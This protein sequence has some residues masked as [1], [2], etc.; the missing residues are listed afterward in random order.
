MRLTLF[1]SSSALGAILALSACSSP[2]SEAI[3]VSGPRA[4]ALHVDPAAQCPRAKYS[5][6]C[7]TITPSGSVKTF[8]FSCKGGAGGCP[9]PKWIMFNLFYT[10]KGQRANGVLGGRW[11]PNPYHS[12][13]STHTI[14][15]IHER[16]PLKP[17]NEVQYVE[18]LLACPAQSSCTGLG[19][20]GIIPKS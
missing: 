12:G 19:G 5:L 10:V 7:V 16:K 2:G 3:T 14:N 4:A 1:S 9:V 18:T 17:S 15:L 20:V 8:T 11:D 13:P 6:G